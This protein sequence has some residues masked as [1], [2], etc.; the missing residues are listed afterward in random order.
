MLIEHM[1]RYAEAFNL[2]L[3]NSSTVEASCFNESKGTWHF[4]VQT[5]WG[6]K[7]VVA[8]H[9]VQATGSVAST[10]YLPSIPGQYDGVSIHSAEYKNPKVLSQEGVK[11]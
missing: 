1:K 6:Q 10:P 7:T 11:V 9:L 4:K 3:L 2:N 5:P 8:K